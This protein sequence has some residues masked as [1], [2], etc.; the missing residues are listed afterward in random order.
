VQGDLAAEVPRLIRTEL[1][2]PAPAKG[3]LGSFRVLLARG[4][5]PKM[6]TER[7]IAAAQALARI[8]GK[9]YWTLPY[10]EPEWVHI[11]AGE[12]WMGSEHGDRDEQ[13][14]HRLYLDTFWIARVPITNAQYHLFTQATGHRP[15]EG[16]EE[17]RPPKGQESHPVVSVSWDDAIAYCQWLSQ[18]TGKAITLPS[19]AEWEKAA[20]GDRDAREYP[21]GDSFDL[22]HCNSWELGL[23]D[24]TPVGIFPNG[25]SPYGC[26]DIAG[27]V[28]EW[29][30]SLWRDYPYDPKDGR[31]DL[32]SRHP[33]VVRGGAFDG[34]RWYVRCACRYW[35]YPD[36]LHWNYGFRLVVSPL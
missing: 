13:P 5:T 19:E 36:A 24:T 31:Q 6:L 11:P 33:R 9:N 26:L 18:V 4:M 20:R 17:N 30:R 15:P 22:T 10:G 2:T 35:N 27:N 3:L 8:G 12:F 25:A 1:E 7:R 32:E 29:T 16:W 34:D 21:W 23:G 14:L 28:W